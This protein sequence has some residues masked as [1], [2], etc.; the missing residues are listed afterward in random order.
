MEKNFSN[1]SILKDVR[2]FNKETLREEGIVADT[3]IIIS[4]GYPA[5]H[6]STAGSTETR[7]MIA[8][9]GQRCLELSKNQDRLDCW[10]KCC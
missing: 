7:K 2:K 5:N 9:S 3:I 6:L 8:T 10:R 1:V 4:G